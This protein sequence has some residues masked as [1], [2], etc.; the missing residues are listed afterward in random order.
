MAEQWQIRRGTT[1]ENNDFTGAAGEISMDTTTNGLRVHDGVT[2]GGFMID[3]VVDFQIPTAQNNYTWYRRYASGWVEQGGQLQT[4]VS[5][6]TV[7]LPVEMSDTY[8]SIM[9]SIG[10]Y[11][12][13]GSGGYTEIF[14]WGVRTTTQFHADSKSGSGI[15]GNWEVKGMAAQGA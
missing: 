14:G 7:T 13:S 5:S 12:G 3:T 4:N 8:Y 1:A 15:T 11:A 10:N 9:F 2:Q 6:E